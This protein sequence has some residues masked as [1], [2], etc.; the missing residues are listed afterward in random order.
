MSDNIFNSFST[1]NKPRF[2]FDDLLDSD[3]LVLKIAFLLLVVFAFIV[4][5]RLCVTIIG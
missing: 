4:L 5:L 2:N 3:S 1:T